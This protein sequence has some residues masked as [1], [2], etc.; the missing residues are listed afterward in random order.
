MKEEL[1]AALA[2]RRELG[3]QYEDHVAAALAERIDSLIDQRV[4]AAMDQTRKQ[5]KSDSEAFLKVAMPVLGFGVPLTIVGAIVAGADGFYVV[6]AMIFVINVLWLWRS[7][8][9]CFATDLSARL[10]CPTREANVD[11]SKSQVCPLLIEDAE[12]CKEALCTFTLAT[13]S[14]TEFPHRPAAAPHLQA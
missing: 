13:T 9:S 7:R 1:A 4:Q 2:A 14:G 8:Q 3:E 10:L 5:A 12:P 11:S 6:V